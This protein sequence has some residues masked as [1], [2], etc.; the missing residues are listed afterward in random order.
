[1]TYIFVD[2]EMEHI[3]K[4]YRNIPGVCVKEIIEIGAVKL[5]EQFQEIDRFK[6]YV[7]PKYCSGITAKIRS[8]TGITN[9]KIVGAKSFEVS[10]LEFVSW[11]YE[12]SD[13]EINVFDWSGT[14][15]FQARSEAAFKLKA[16]G[17]EVNNLF[18]HWYDFQKDYCSFFPGKKVM[19]LEYALNYIGMSFEGRPHDALNDAHNTARL[20]T[21][22]KTT[23]V[24]A[25][26]N[27]IDSIAGKQNKLSNSMGALF[28]FS[29]FSAQLAIA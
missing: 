19:S 28:D 10:F 5:D 25:T 22:T 11:C 13:D 21:E 9:S 18:T 20:Y 2:F 26:R 6:V 23:D 1:M 4:K 8:L 27:K 24:N 12:D 17:Q 29:A 15:L 14:D 7:K 16:V 3:D